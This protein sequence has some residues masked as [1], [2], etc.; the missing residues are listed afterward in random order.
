MQGL[1][2]QANG[3]AKKRRLEMQ[4]CAAREMVPRTPAMPAA[5]SMDHH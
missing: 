5:I 1:C 4:E 3:K 2:A